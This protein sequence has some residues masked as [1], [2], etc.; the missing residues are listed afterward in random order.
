MS[1][2]YPETNQYQRQHQGSIRAADMVRATDQRSEAS[3]NTEIQE[4]YGSSDGEKRRSSRSMASM[5]S[6]AS[7]NIG[8]E[9]QVRPDTNSTPQ[10]YAWVR[11]TLDRAEGLRLRENGEKPDIVATVRSLSTIPS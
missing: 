9:L 3:E 4:I 10:T 7:D 1:T 8:S 11:I 6:M 5:A 2:R